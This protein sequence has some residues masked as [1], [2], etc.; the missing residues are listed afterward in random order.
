VLET[1]EFM[2]LAEESG[3]TVELG[4]WCLEQACRDAAGW[5]A[6]LPGVPVVVNLSAR[7]LE[8]PELLTEVAGFL[9]HSGL[10]PA[11]LTLEVAERAA[12]HDAA[13]TAETLRALRQLGSRIAL[14]QFGNGYSSLAYLT[15]FPIDGLKIEG[16]IAAHLEDLETRALVRGVV[17]LARALNLRVGADDVATAEQAA[18]LRALGCQTA[19]G[20]AF[21]APCLLDE[22][23]IT[24]TAAAA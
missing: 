18:Q 17:A 16:A 22:L 20:D 15:R 3:R 8:H 10:A 5:Q 13:A 12:M 2:P 24:G 14:D 4:R 19:Q 9:A 11:L 1:A 6:R 21:A 7:Q 23:L